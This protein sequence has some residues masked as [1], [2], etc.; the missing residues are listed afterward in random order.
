MLIAIHTW[1]SKSTYETLGPFGWFYG[2]FFIED[3]PAELYY[4]GIF[5]FMNNPERSMGG[6]TFFGLAVICGSRLVLVQA[7]LAVL[8][9]W[10]FLSMVEKLVSPSW[11]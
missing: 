11:S 10:W 1:A 5:R 9:H 7:C 2:D 3:Y 6:A 4:T 8:S